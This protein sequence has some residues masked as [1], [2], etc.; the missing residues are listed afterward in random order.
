MALPSMTVAFIRPSSGQTNAQL[1]SGGLASNSSAA[2]PPTLN[3]QLCKLIGLGFGE[4]P[5]SGIKHLQPPR[6]SMSSSP[7]ELE[8]VVCEPV[9]Y[10]QIYSRNGTLILPHH[11]TGPLHG[12]LSGSS[13]AT[14]RHAQERRKRSDPSR[15]VS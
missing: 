12:C 4:S 13:T 11:H 8:T 14:A 3:I 7:R 9:H 1:G 15:G 10:R 6:T 2:T 5:H